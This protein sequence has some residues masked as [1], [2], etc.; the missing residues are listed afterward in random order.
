MDMDETRISTAKTSSRE[1]LTR[2]SEISTNSNA[3]DK[4]Q[5]S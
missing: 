5:T 2:I 3:P 4:F 1:V